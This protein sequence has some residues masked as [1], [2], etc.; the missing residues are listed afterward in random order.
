MA[1]D[2]GVV[3][4]GREGA[5]G[6]VGDGDIVEGDAG[7][8]VEGGDDGDGLVGDE[9][10]VGVFVLVGGFYPFCDL[11]VSMCIYVFDGGVEG[12]CCALNRWPLPAVGAP[13]W[14]PADIVVWT[15]RYGSVRHE[16]AQVVR[17]GML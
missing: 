13:F 3:G 7:F 14:I 10:D 11:V 12:L 8:E 5:V 16:S 6:F 1:D 15:S 4:L 2:H 17:H 9:F